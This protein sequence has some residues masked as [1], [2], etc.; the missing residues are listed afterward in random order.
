MQYITVRLRL[1]PDDA[2]R[3]AILAFVRDVNECCNWISMEAQIAQKFRRF[4]LHHLV[5]YRAREAFGLPGK[6]TCQAIAKVARAYALGRKVRRFQSMGSVGVGT[7]NFRFVTAATIRFAK[8]GHIPFV[9]NPKHR[10]LL[11]GK[12]GEAKLAVSGNAISLLVPFAVETPEATA[13]DVTGFDLGVQNIATGSDGTRYSGADLRGIRC[14]RR[15]LRAKLQSKGTRSARRR[16]KRLRRREDRFARDINHQIS[17]RIVADA[18]R[19]KSA[20][21][22]EELRGIRSR[23]RA[24]R[25]Q[26][27]VLHSWSFGQLRSFI[28]Y[29]AALAGVP[30]I[31]VDPRNSSRECSSC[32]HVDK[33]NRPNQATFRCRMC[34]YSAHADYNAAL[35]IRD[36]GRA[37]LNAPYATSP[38]GLVASPFGVS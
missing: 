29:K 9:V 13:S 31:L 30:V 25:Q 36:R 8:F 27:A 16:L 2:T 12:Y 14:R 28:T 33:K 10:H 6:A 3:D 21:A 1:L 20:I 26:R 22:I 23:V 15:R 35:V 24:S 4:D 5:Y 38:H 17:K 11:G 19:T 18:E 32:G 7:E 34:G 37:H